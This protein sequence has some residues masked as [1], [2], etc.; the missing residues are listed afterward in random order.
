M[1]AQR[2]NHVET[3]VVEGIEYKLFTD[4]IGPAIMVTD[5]DAGEVVTK[6]NYKTEA[7]AG[8]MFDTAVAAAKKTH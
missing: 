2:R 1:T 4:S 8:Q 6:L 3:E 5:L 7:I